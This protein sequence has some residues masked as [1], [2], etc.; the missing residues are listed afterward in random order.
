[1]KFSCFKL[2]LNVNALLQKHLS[3]SKLYL[4][5]SKTKSKIESGFQLKFVFC[6]KIIGNYLSN[7]CNYII[8]IFCLL[9][10]LVGLDKIAL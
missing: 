10:H 1:M 5:L 6:H 3:F 9:M 8:I 2:Q 7:K 4:H